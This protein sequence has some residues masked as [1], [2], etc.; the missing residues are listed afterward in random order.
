MN[1]NIKKI[2]PTY[3][4]FCWRLRVILV[5][6]FWYVSN[7]LKKGVSPW[8]LIKNTIVSYVGYKTRETLVLT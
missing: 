6:E 7:I 4:Y 8:E 5:K 1:Q 2:K 3:L